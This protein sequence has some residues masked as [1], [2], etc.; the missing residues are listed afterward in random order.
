[1][2]K[3]PRMITISNQKGLMPTKAIDWNNALDRKWLRNH[4]HW[5]I[6]NNITVTITPN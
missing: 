3:E 2:A 6:C 5:A 1:M 4:M